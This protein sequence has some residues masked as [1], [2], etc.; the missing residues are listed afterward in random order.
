MAALLARLS[1]SWAAK[2]LQA[3]IRAATGL[4]GCALQRTDGAN[5]KNNDK[6]VSDAPVGEWAGVTTNDS[7]RVTKVSLESNQF[8]RYHP[9]RVGQPRQPRKAGP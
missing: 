8:D 3:A 5:W 6:W 7:G 2:P 9:A 4:R 1:T